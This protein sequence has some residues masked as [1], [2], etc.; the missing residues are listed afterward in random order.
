MSSRRIDDDAPARTD[1]DLALDVALELIA[2]C[3]GNKDLARI[4][5][6]VAAT[7]ADWADLR[8]AFPSAKTT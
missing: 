2:I 6:D 5:V 4:A 3:H 1:I 8:Q 7:P